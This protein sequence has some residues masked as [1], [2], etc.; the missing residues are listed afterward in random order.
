MMIIRVCLF[1]FGCLCC[2]ANAF[3]AT[4]E[5]V[6]PLYSQCRADVSYKLSWVTGMIW[7]D[8]H[9]DDRSTTRHPTLKGAS[10]RTDMGS[11]KLV[12]TAAHNLFLMGYGKSEVEAE[13]RKL[14]LGFT[15]EEIYKVTY[16]TSVSVGGLSR[17]PKQIARPSIG[18]G[19]SELD[20]VVLYLTDEDALSAY[21]PILLA[22]KLPS[23]GESVRVV[24]VMENSQQQVLTEYSVSAVAAQS[25]YFLLNK[26]VEN[27]FSGGVVMD[28]DKE[29][30]YGVIAGNV[31]NKQTKVY[32]VTE[33][34]LA[35]AKPEP[36]GDVLRREE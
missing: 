12:V 34:L 7:K 20:V 17:K 31:N 18:G 19:K 25:G 32:L 23:A 36:A 9:Y 15:L 4:G 29:V 30:A 5:W 3:S 6:Q 22:S 14:L 13:L 2:S 8:K 26:P 27:G 16:S 35:A 28:K 33:S 10:W 1:A 11:Q 21:R 24:G